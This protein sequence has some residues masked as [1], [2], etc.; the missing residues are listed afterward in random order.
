VLLT[1]VRPGFVRTPMTAGNPYPMP[2]MMAPERAAAR[3]VAGLERGRKFITFPLWFAL[4]AR[5]GNLL[6]KSLFARVPGK[7]AAP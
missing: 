4:L 1:L 5:M 6:P 3:I 2:G 7:P